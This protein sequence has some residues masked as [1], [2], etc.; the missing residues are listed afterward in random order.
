MVI[1]PKNI[2]V[3]LITW[4]VFS[5][6]CVH[7]ILAGALYHMVSGCLHHELDQRLA[8]YTTCLVELLPQH[9]Q[10]N[11]AEVID[12]MAELTALGPDLYVRV[13]DQTGRLVYA[14]SGLPTDVSARLAR[15]EM[16]HAAPPRTIR[17]PG[18][19]SW[20]MITQTVRDGAEASYVGHVA[21]PLRGVQQALARLLIILLLVVP[22]VMLLASAGAWMLLNRALKPLD[23]VIRTVQVIQA[24]DLSQRLEVVKTGDEVQALA[25]TFNHMIERLQ[26][27]F[28][29]MRQ[30]ISDASHELRTPLTVLKGEL[31][32]GLRA[33]PRSDSCDILA[34]C[35]GE[36]QRLSRLV[37]TLLVLSNADAG[38]TD[39]NLQPVALCRILEDIVEQ[40]KM[41]AEPKGIRVEFANGSSPI[42]RAD[43]MRLKQLLLNLVDNAVKYTPERGQIRLSYHA[44]NGHVEIR[45]ADTGIGIDPKDVPRIFDRFYR[46][47]RSRSRSEGSYG[48][49]L[50][51][52]KWIAEAHHGTI[53]VESAPGKGSTF[54]V[55]L[56]IA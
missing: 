3:R 52:C 14:S 29:H 31:E 55:R 32:L 4:Y 38:K 54:L 1:N 45:V 18:H 8:T 44:D 6:G 48:L 19:G 37:D 43:A 23:E 16:P 51:I 50:S 56:P 2:R 49:G 28:A 34:T 36:I 22:G 17:L 12:E 26:Q 53:R 15:S 9:R 11:L 42:V 35:S 40:A 33:C 30:F 20:R 25:E 7:L 13:T 21:I 41:L 10:L 27:S 39:F 47:D 24:H 46:A 5:L